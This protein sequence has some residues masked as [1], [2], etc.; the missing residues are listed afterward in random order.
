VESRLVTRTE[1]LERTRFAHGVRANENP[2]LPRRKSAEY[3]GFHRL[4]GAKAKVGL[5]AG[6]RVGREAGALLERDPDLIVPVEL[7]RWRCDEAELDGFA[8]RQR[9]D[10]GFLRARDRRRIVVETCRK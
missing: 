3:A 9:A 6:Q 1:Y 8:G 4:H 10:C 2:V 5:H 7:V